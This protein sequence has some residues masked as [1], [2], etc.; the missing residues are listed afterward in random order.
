MQGRENTGESLISMELLR[1]MYPNS[2]YS[3]ETGGIMKN[4]RES[5]TNQ[6]VRDY[7]AKFYRPDN[8]A[9]IVTGQVLPED[10]FKAI[11]PLEER[12]IAKGELPSF[13]R[14][15]ET[16]VPPLTESKDIKIVFP[17]DE[18][19]FGLVNIGWRGPNCSNEN[20]TLTACSIL[21]R[22]LSDTSVSPLQRDFVEIEDPFASRVGYNITE[23]LESLIYFLFENV[24]LTK[25]DSIHERLQATLNKIANGEEKLDMK[26]MFS[27]IERQVLESLSSLENTPHD[28][29]AFHLIGYVLYGHNEKD[30][31]ERLN[32]NEQLYFLQTMDEHYWLELLQKY[33][34]D[35]NYVVVRAYPS[36]EKQQSMAKEESDRI[37]KQREELGE[38]GL[39]LKEKFLADAMSTNEIS[40]PDEMLTS[41]PVPSKEGMQ[42]HPVEIYRSDDSKNLNPTGLDLKSFPIF[43][44]AYNIHTNFVYL[45][46]S[47]NTDSLTPELRMYLPLLLELLMESP[48]R[49]GDILIPY[50]EIVQALES[51][52]ISTDLS[53]GL[54]SSNHFSCGPF[55][56]TATLTLEVEQRKY[57]IGI[58][59]LAELLFRTEFTV[60]R[61]KVCAAKMA[62]DVAQLKREGDSVAKYLMNAMFY[63]K[64]SNVQLVSLLKQHKF[65]NQLIVELED[66]DKAQSIIDNLNKTRET[67]TQLKNLGAHVAA[68]WDRLAE[69]D[70][71]LNISW[72]KLAN[73]KQVQP[74]ESL[75]VYQ[76]W[77]LFDDAELKD[78]ITGSVIGIGCVESAFLY[79]GSPG[80][81]DFNDPDLPALMLF[82]QYLTQLE[83]PLWRQIRGQGFAYGYSI[84]PKPHEGLLYLSLYRASNLV[85][86]YKEAKRITVSK[87][88]NGS[89]QRMLQ[90]F[91][92]ISG[93]SITS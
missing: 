63:K 3:S 36:I 85:A 26:R 93:I 8:L 47:M 52:T 79:Q 71:D 35:S 18:E 83:G 92:I 70:F 28:D 20:L 84:A 78:N 21:L 86:A 59:W 57:D 37:E 80:I 30:F 10:L 67:I 62:N 56:N 74:V 44:E 34:I 19:D 90:F 13:E 77:Q 60:A 25:I 39:L 5:T 33:I 46:L 45:T 1:A 76:D 64:D 6:K 51:D 38:K 23:N 55:S 27:I 15:W 42:F 31:I 2:G 54:E 12:I 49:R 50:E 65:L 72:S 16:P 7:H 75:Q 48:I 11:K 58:N 9:I 22:Y 66:A 53:L 61:I 89:F 24:P 91:N 73:G 69:L 4:L 29:V 43:A 87:L 88:F 17:S 40:C 41:I 82:L 32:V 81:K 14:P 68:D